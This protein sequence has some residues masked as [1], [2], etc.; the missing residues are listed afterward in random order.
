[1]SDISAMSLSQPSI[2]PEQIA[3]LLPEFRPLSQAVIAHFEQR[4]SGL[5]QE[6]AT[7]K[8]ELATA[9]AELVTAR[10]AKGCELVSGRSMWSVH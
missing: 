5:E 4:F 8:T 2:P 6:L 9:R 7:V 10:K 3:V 1:M